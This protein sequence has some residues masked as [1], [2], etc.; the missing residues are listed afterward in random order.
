MILE[1]IRERRRREQAEEVPERGERTGT[2]TTGIVSVLGGRKIAL[3]FT[4]HQHAGENLRDVLLK[5]AADPDVRWAGAKRAGA[6][7]RTP[8]DSLQL[9]C[10]RK[11]AVRGR[12]VQV[13][14][15]VPLRA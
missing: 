14:R 1:T 8:G 4:G 7:R 13:S 11:K 15:G 10:A 2:F 12:G 6:S 9:Q 3:F 5:R